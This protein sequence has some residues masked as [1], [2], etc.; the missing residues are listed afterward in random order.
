MLEKVTYNRLHPITEYRDNLSEWQ[1]GFCQ[2]HST[3]DA[4][5][6]ALKLA[7]DTMAS[8][9]FCVVITLD[10]KDAFISAR[11]KW[12]S[13]KVTSRYDTNKGPKQ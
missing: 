5:D 12:S 9:K 11:W 6:V 4:V 2:N 10:I 3:I 7:R 8:K 13:S 1:F